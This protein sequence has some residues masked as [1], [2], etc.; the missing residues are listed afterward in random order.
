MPVRQHHSF[1]SA[2]HWYSLP[3]TDHSFCSLDQ[4]K[5]LLP[6]P[7]VK[8]SSSTCTQSNQST[9]TASHTQLAG[10]HADMLQNMSYIAQEKEGSL[11]PVSEQS[12]STPALRLGKLSQCHGCYEDCGAVTNS[13]D[14]PEETPAERAQVTPRGA[15]NGWRSASA[16]EL[17]GASS[18]V[19]LKKCRLLN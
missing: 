11:N 19:D 3:P 18:G 8:H 7:A 2:A 17:R 9:L 14:L 1:L 5:L 13:F 6:T 10:M 15:G 16:T 4:E 12:L